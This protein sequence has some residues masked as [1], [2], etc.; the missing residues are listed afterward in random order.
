M[1]AVLVKS[2]PIVMVLAKYLTIQ[3]RTRQPASTPML[4]E[5]ELRLLDL[6]PMQKVLVRVQLDQV[7]TQKVLV[8][9]QVEI[10]LMPKVH[11]V[12]LTLRRTQK[13]GEL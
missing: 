8:R 11:Q 13:A 10:I 4:K 7:L 1:L 9:K 6:L 2:T 12:L 3:M 5:L